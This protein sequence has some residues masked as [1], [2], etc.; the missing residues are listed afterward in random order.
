MSDCQ[1]RERERPYWRKT[2]DY[3][4]EQITREASNVALYVLDQLIQAFLSDA[5]SQPMYST[6]TSVTCGHPPL[7]FHFQSIE[8]R[9]LDQNVD[10]IMNEDARG[11][12]GLTHVMTA[13]I[14]SHTAARRYLRPV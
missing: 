3:N 4:V 13:A 2:R 7:R 11:E 10:R 1:G 12:G 8:P 14:R 5:L 6:Q 9:E